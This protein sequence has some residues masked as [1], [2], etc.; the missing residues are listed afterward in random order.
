MM[1]PLVVVTLPLRSNSVKGAGSSNSRVP[2][3]RV[4]GWISSVSRPGFVGGYDALASGM[5]IVSLAH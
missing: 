2:L 3:P 1:T 4:S 5:I